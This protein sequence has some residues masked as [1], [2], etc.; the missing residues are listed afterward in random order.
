MA[1]VPDVATVKHHK[2]YFHFCSEQCRETFKTTPQLFASGAVEKH[3]PVIKQRNLRLAKTRDPD[4]VE[5][6]E[7]YLLELMGV[8]E[9]HFQGT[10]LQITYDLLQVTQAGI[11]QL[12]IKLETALDNSWWQRLRRGWVHNAEQNELSNLVRGTGACCNQPPPR[13]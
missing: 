5:V 3:S 10:R 13:V 8:T 1:V 9:V 12:L 2:M 11:E 6:I 7:G 4:E